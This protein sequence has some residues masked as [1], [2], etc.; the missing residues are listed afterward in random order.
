MQDLGELYVAFR[1]VTA[2]FRLP[3][4]TMCGNIDIIITDLIN[5]LSSL[6]VTVLLAEFSATLCLS[7]LSK[8]TGILSKSE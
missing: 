3:H 6:T 1:R 5:K 8:L 2:S 4:T 7:C